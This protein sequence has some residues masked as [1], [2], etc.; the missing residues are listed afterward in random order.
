[1]EKEPIKNHQDLKVY[2]M[3]FDAAMKIF[4][5]SKKFPVEERYSLTDQ[6]RRS[7]RSVCANL[8]EAWRKRRYEAAFVAKLND[9]E[10]EAAETQTWIEFAVKCNYL[11]VELG[12][13]LYGI[14]NRILGGLV[15][16]ITDPSPW[17][18]KR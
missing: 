6:I 2:Q 14:Y 8:A 18:M 15:N 13:E 10:A 17:L 9:C 1:M 3:A 4:E 16:M 12:R 11:D 5:L 7:S